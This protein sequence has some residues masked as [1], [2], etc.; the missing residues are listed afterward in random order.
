MAVQ[1]PS[2]YSFFTP[3]LL[4]VCCKMALFGMFG[5]ADCFHVIL[6]YKGRLR[7][8]DLFAAWRKSNQNKSTTYQLHSSSHSFMF[9][10]CAVLSGWHLCHRRSLHNDGSR[11][12]CGKFPRDTI[13]MVRS[14][15]IKTCFTVSTL[16]CQFGQVDQWQWLI[17]LYFLRW[18]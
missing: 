17:R 11:M 16:K 15:S 2:K 7:Q 4:R 5:I 13:P 6:M 14:R 10:P 18:H 9:C 8:F 3:L 1:M 12:K